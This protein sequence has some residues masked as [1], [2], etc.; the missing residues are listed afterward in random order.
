MI[1]QMSMATKTDY[2]G[3]RDGCSLADTDQI[4]WREGL[5]QMSC[6]AVQAMTS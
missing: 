3:L 4:S 6:W 1:L 5:A 2:K